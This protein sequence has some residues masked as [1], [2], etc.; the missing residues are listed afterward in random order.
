LAEER[1]ANNAGNEDENN[2]EAVFERSQAVLVSKKADGRSL[3]L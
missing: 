3:E 2:Q 1:D